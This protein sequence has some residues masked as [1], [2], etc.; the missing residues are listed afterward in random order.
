MR[1]ILGDNLTQPSIRDIILIGSFQQN[2]STNRKLLKTVGRN[3][4]RKIRYQVKYG[5]KFGDRLI[6]F[7]K[8]FYSKVLQPGINKVAKPV[9]NATKKII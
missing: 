8:S 6:K 5:G 9:Y 4:F 7:G 1:L 2:L 3:N